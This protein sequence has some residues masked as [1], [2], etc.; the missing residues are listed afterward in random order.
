[1]KRRSIEIPGFKHDNPIPSASRI[2]PFVVS[3]AISGKDPQSGK[4]PDGIDEQC[5]LVFAHMRRIIEAASGTTEDIL[6][7]T[8]WLKDGA[9]RKVVNQEWLRMFPDAE[10]RPARHTF[11]GQEL[12]GNTLVQCE[13]LAVLNGGM[14]GAQ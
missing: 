6:K 12:A 4:V 2:G 5:A 13:F 9:H 7:V 11:T 14:P 10:S 1:M 3:G 8:V